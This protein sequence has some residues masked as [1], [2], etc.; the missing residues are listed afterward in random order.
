MKYKTIGAFKNV[1]NVPYCKATVD[2]QVGNGVLIDRA[3]KEAKLPASEDDAKACHR[4][5]TNIS[6]KPEKE[7]F[8]DTTLHAKGEYIRADD[9]LSVANMEIELA[10]HEITDGVDSL[11]AG[12]KLTFDETGKIKKN[13]TVDGYAIYFEVIEKTPYLGKGIL[14]VIRSGVLSPSAAPVI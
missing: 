7:T 10:D 8:L 3:K 9:L 4:I 13:T 12:D 2:M 14:A 6:D 11:A 1:Q 5:V